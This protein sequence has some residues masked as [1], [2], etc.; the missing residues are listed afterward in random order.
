MGRVCVCMFHLWKYYI[1]FSE[2]HLLLV[3]EFDFG[4]YYSSLIPA[5]PDV[6]YWNVYWSQ[7]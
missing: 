3:S 1:D 4:S 6:L 2:V 5:I 7:T